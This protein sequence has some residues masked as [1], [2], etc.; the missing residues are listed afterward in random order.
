MLF[1]D[2]VG[3]TE[4]KESLRRRIRS[5]DISHAN[6]F[7]GPEGSGHFPLAMAFARYACCPNRTDDDSC[8]TCD[9]CQKFDSYQYA[10]L[11]FTFP[12]YKKSERSVS[13]G[14]MSEWRELLSTGAYF[15]FEQW[16]AMLNAETKQLKMYVDEASEIVQQLSLKSYEG[17]YKIQVIWMPELLGNDVSNK[18]LKVIEEPPA[19][20]LFLMVGNSLDRVLGTIVSRTQIVHVNVI[21]DDDMVK[22]LMEK[23]GSNQE[24]ANDIAHFVE[25]NYVKALRVMNDNGGQ[26]AFL[27]R[28]RDW[29]RSCYKRD[30]KQISVFA[31]EMGK[32]SREA[33]KQF[34]GYTLHFVRQCI[35]SNYGEVDLARFTR[36]EQSF[37]SKFA[38]FIHH[39]NVISITEL[40]NEAFRDVERNANQRLVF[41]DLSLKM[42]QELHRKQ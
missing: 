35:V 10:D 16:L 9:V 34:L 24:D 17:R 4:L 13:A 42:H 40:L 39:K 27:A 15:D 19:D 31:Q 23:H 22:V 36:E 6:M 38:P 21:D 37:A 29:M 1:K 2:I 12:I 26:E 7:V 30:A 18:L 5:G 41:M 14:F 3:Q 32:G 20:T 25:G 11:H 33:Q 8:G 28:F